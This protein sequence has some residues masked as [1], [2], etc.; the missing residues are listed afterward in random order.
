MTGSLRKFWYHLF[1]KE[2]NG[3]LLIR[4]DLL[5]FHSVVLECDIVI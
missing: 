4:T 2:L 5:E 3:P 1:L